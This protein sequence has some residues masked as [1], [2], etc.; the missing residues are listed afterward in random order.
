MPWPQHGSGSAPEFAGT[1]KEAPSGGADDASE[2]GHRGGGRSRVA[3]TM[4]KARVGSSLSRISFLAKS[5]RLQGR[6]YLSGCKVAPWLFVDGLLGVLG[7]DRKTLR[8]SG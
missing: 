2:T 7:D 8:A 3:D 4:L 5:G 6:G 1:K